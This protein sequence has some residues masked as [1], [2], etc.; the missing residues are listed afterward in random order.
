MKTKI[1]YP[2]LLFSFFIFFNCNRNNDEASQPT[3]ITPVEIGKGALY[4]N[5]QEDIVRSNVVISNNFDWQNLMSQMNSVNNV[6]DGFTETNI[7][8]SQYEIIAVF[9][10][11]YNNG[12]WSIDIIS[13]VENS[14]NIEVT[15]SNENEGDIT[16]ITVQPY[17][18]VKIPKSTKPVVFIQD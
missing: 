9:D 18:I 7:D 4:G 1:F 8:F 10:S 13:I 2:I 6:T 3:N 15:I 5:G 16:S 14:S 11:I 17:H 12:G